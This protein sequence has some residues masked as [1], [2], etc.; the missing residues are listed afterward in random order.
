MDLITATFVTPDWI[1]SG[2][3]S[4]VYE[5]VGGVIRDTQS[6]QIVAWLKEAGMSSTLNPLSSVLQFTSAVSVLNLGISVVGFAVIAQR[7]KELE[8]RLQ[9]AQNVLIKID[10]RVDLAFY[11]NF[12]AALDLAT[13]AFT[14]SKPENRRD[15]ALAAINRFLEAEHIYI[16]CIEQ[17]LER[18]SQ[19]VDEYILTS[20]LAYIAEARCYLE[21]EEFETVPRRLQDGSEK[22]RSCIFKYIEMLLTS[23]P[24]AYLDPQF[25]DQIN[26]RRLTKI[27]QW[28]D[29]SLDENAVFE[30]QRENLFNLRDEQN[31]TS[32]YKWVNSLPA[33]IVDSTEVKGNI[34]GNR[35]Q[36]KEEAM[37][38]LPQ[39]MEMMESLIETHQRFEAYQSEVNAIAQLGINF[40][41]W[42]KIAPAEAQPKEANFMYLIPAMPMNV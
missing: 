12:R 25:K 6:K 42:M 5:R 8:K 18:K 3:N 11:A 41:D 34:L 39:T 28:I 37:K 7:L 22:I 15:S 26:L 17:E 21:L 20:V 31:F 36:M 14:L 33:A 32:G 10:Q 2:L 27:Y 40:H 23:N 29:P 19:I 30:L 35:D 1:T 24:A 13:N 9:Q 38:R 16:G 4:G